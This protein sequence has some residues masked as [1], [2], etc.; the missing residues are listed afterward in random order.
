MA[1]S[2]ANRP[3][4]LA[5]YESWN[6]D[7]WR[8][9]LTPEQY[10]IA[11]LEQT[12]AAYTPGNHHDEERPGVYACIACGEPVFHS[13]A[14]FQASTGWPSFYDPIAPEAVVTRHDFKMVHPRTA[15]HCA[16]CRSHLGHVYK[17]G[18]A[19]TGLRFSI[20]G[21]VLAFVRD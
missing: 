21:T 15:V 6:E 3:V 5:Q 2:G 7:D 19:P 11:R 4:E 18:P 8:V 13:R 10:D 17:D 1:D 16:A 14:K 12:E 20:N 9:R